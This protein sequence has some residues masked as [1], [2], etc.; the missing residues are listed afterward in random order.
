MV[1]KMGMTLP[2]PDTCF[3]I[4][5]LKSDHMPSSQFIGIITSKLRARHVTALSCISILFRGDMYPLVFN[6]CLECEVSNS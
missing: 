1:V 3:F 6:I 4:L 2:S 5:N